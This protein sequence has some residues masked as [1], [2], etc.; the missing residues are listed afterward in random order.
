ML[1]NVF[2]IDCDMIIITSD[3]LRNLRDTYKALKGNESNILFI[4]QGFMIS[5][6]TSVCV[7]ILDA[8]ATN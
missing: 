1:P 4:L 2:N 8:D 6:A 7:T 5:S 3:C